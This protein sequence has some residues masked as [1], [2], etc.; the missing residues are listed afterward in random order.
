MTAGLSRLFYYSLKPQDLAHIKISIKDLLL[1]KL[2]YKL[3]KIEPK[4][5]VKLYSIRIR[6]VN[7]MILSAIQPLYF[8]LFGHVCALWIK[9]Y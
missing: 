9:V 4:Q 8:I 6:N 3:V 2:M 7:N 1:N 5:L